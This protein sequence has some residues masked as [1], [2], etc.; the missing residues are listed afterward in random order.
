MVNSD[1]SLKEGV[2]VG[3]GQKV[4]SLY[5]K[6]VT[7]YGTFIAVIRAMAVYVIKS[8]PVKK[9]KRRIENRERKTHK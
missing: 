4:A 8:L 7:L 5:L 6:M 3:S 1:L 2:S 9:K